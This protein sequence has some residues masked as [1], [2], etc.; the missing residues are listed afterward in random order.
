[1]SPYYW[2]QSLAA[3]GF[4]FSYLLPTYPW[5]QTNFGGNFSIPPEYEN[6]TLAELNRTPFPANTRLTILYS[7]YSKPWYFEPG[8]SK[9]KAGQYA[10]SYDMHH[11]FGSGGDKEVTIWS[12]QGYSINFVPKRGSA[13]SATLGDEIPAF[14]GTRNKQRI[15]MGNLPHSGVLNRPEYI[16]VIF[17]R[18]YRLD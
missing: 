4:N 9:T 3:R 12:A 11:Y 10:D 18:L 13:P 15:P 5:K 1:M 2:R 7:D 17:N 6:P 8:G 14:A 16:D